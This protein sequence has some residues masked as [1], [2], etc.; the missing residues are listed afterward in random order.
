MKPIVNQD[1]P[2]KQE[3]TSKVR[4]I[5]DALYVLNGKWKLPLIFTLRQSPLRFNEI[6]KLI[7][8]IT[9][10]VLAKELRDMEINE[11]IVKKVHPTTPV[12]VIYE[13]TA[14]S[15]TLKSVLYELGIWGEQHREKIRQSIRGEA[16]KGL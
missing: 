5:S 14:Y 10:K 13:A 15:D 9:P 3:C 6:L 7:E 8:G 12:T 16:I 1:V 4:Y 2:A 11:F